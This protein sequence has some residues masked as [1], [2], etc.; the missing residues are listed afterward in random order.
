MMTTWNRILKTASCDNSK[1]N[2][3]T[4]RKCQSHS[5]ALHDDLSLP[6]KFCFKSIKSIFLLSVFCHVFSGGQFR[7]S[8]R[9]LSCHAFS[10]NPQ[11]FSPRFQSKSIPFGNKSPVAA[12]AKNIQSVESEVSQTKIQKPEKSNPI[13]AKLKKKTVKDLREMMKNLD[14]PPSRGILS[15]LKLKNDLVDFLANEISIRSKQVDEKE[16]NNSEILSSALSTTTTTVKK[17]SV[18]NKTDKKKA[19]VSLPSIT[20]HLSS[21]DD[22]K[23]DNSNEKTNTITS[24]KSKKDLIFEEVL[25]RYPGLEYPKP[26]L[27]ASPDETSEDSQKDLRTKYHP[28]LRNAPSNSEMDINFVGTASCTPGSTRGVSCTALR[29]N[30]RRKTQFLSADVGG[31]NGG[32]KKKNDYEFTGG[33]WLFDSGECTQVR[34]YIQMLLFYF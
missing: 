28:M 21:G 24:F 9:V 10:P 7:F 33:T 32:D 27:E 17:R 30:W 1:I 26:K 25:E 4:N 23:A 14:P 20:P 22:K 31:V 3:I 2:Q 15:K 19:R 6:R 12:Y 5:S 29:L 34:Q 11:L 8:S 13:V 16:E 18:K